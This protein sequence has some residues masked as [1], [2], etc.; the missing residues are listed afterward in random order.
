MATDEITHYRE[1]LIAL[2]SIPDIPCYYL[3]RPPTDILGQLRTSYDYIKNA[4]GSTTSDE[5]LACRIQDVINDAETGSTAI[6]DFG[7][8]INAMLEDNLETE[9]DIYGIDWTRTS[10][11]GKNL[12]SLKALECLDAMIPTINGHDTDYDNPATIRRNLSFVVE[13]MDNYILPYIETESSG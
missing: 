11:I 7:E 5:E 10:H 6:L 1:K 4:F 13:L 9:T 2:K 12:L 3:N 8:A